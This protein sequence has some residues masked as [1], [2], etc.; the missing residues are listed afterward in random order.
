MIHIIKMFW[1]PSFSSPV[2]VNLSLVIFQIHLQVLLT[3]PLHPVINR[4]LWA[5]R[6]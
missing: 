1:F 3:R 5:N 2:T 6:W 4:H